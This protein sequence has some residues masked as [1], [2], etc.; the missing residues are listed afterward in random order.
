[1]NE[2]FFLIEDA[3]EGGYN[4]RAIGE[5]IFT[6]AETIEELNIN[7]ADAIACHFHEMVAPYFVLKFI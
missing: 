1:M 2:I 4:A 3:I 7:V 5:S 6:Q